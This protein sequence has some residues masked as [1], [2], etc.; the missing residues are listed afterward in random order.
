MK[1]IEQL[2][3]LI[4]SEFP[5]L[6]RILGTNHLLPDRRLMEEVILPYF[7]SKKE[8]NRILF[9]GCDWY[10][11]TYNKI[12]N[13]KEYWTIDIDRNKSKFGSSNHLVDS[14]T[15]LDN[16]FNTNYFDVIFCNGVFLVGAMDERKIIEKAFEKCFSCLRHDGILVVGWNNTPELR[17]F[18]LNECQS[19]NLLQPYIFPPL[20]TFQ[21]PT[22]T[23]YKHTYN[24]YIK[25]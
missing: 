20:S 8:F 2:K 10:T 16:Y 6:A 19:L 21:Y 24:F 17:P 13:N 1:T 18:P 3:G 25:K 7:A 11:K 15:N 4:Q 5:A 12:F 9:V 22:N 23:H 14:L